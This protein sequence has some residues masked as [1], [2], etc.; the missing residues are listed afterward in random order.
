M[1]FENLYFLAFAGMSISHLWLF[2]LF[3]QGALLGLIVVVIL[4]EKYFGDDL[5]LDTKPR[6]V[7]FNIAVSQVRVLNNYLTKL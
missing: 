7:V 2:L 3:Q 6:V 4:Y 5:I 1:D